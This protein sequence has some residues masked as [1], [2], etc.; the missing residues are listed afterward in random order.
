[1][2][3]QQDIR[4]LQRFD[5]YQRALKRLQDA[6]DLADSRKLTDI[7]NENLIDHIERVG[8]VFYQS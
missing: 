7:D 5:N 6:K 4:W 3:D 2:G 1:M 8:I